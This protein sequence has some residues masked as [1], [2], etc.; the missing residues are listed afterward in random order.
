MEAAAATQDVGTAQAERMP[1]VSLRSA[2][3]MQSEEPRFVVHDPVAGLGTF[4]FPY[5]QQNAASA[6]AEVRLPIYT[7][8]RIQ[9]S[10]F[11]A[12]AR[13]AAAQ[14]DTDQTRL[15]L[16]YAVGEAYVAVLR[17]RRALEV[18]QY[19]SE[20]LAAHAA[21][22]AQRHAQERVS[23]TDL[24]A[25]Q[26]A[27]AAAEKDVLQQR[28]TLALAEGQFNRL[29]ARPITAPVELDEA[30][31]LKPLEQTYEQLV[32]LAFQRRPDLQRLMALAD[33][34]QFASVSVRATGLP[35]VC[36]TAGARYEENRFS[37][38]QLLA[39]AAV[40]LD[41]RFYDGGASRSAA[42]AEVARATGAR[43][44]VDDSKAQ[45]ALE[46]LDAWNQAARAAEQREVTAQTQAYA[47]ENLRVT[48]LRYE[49]GMAT[50]AEVLEAQSRWS[51]AARD[52]S[53]SHYDGLSA[54]LK[55]RYY[56]ALL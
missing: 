12:E 55:L 43:R 1:T 7:S 16:L 37:E 18:S 3:T 40:L 5:A 52:A 54:E 46:L 4:E 26:A 47:A 27:A 39:S 17:Q 14:F 6:G 20:S 41:W 48:R 45:V 21:A 25:A 50:N 10:I 31:E 36:A 11:S 2:Y 42:A 29:L 19:Q 44:V 51:Q 34:H 32:E 38:P 23:T 28:R 56:A 35:Q 49:Q 15:N 8:G 53:D 24:L 30:E 22:V 33:S 9:N 13:Q